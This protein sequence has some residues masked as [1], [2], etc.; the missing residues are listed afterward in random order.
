MMSSLFRASD[1]FAVP[2]PAVATAVLQPGILV[3]GITT[4]PTRPWP[5]ALKGISF[6]LSPYLLNS[7]EITPAKGAR[8]LLRLLSAFA[9]DD[10]VQSYQL[11]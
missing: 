9:N 10:K 4:S 1:A 8:Q 7:F 6:S 5:A 3:H 2:A 11:S